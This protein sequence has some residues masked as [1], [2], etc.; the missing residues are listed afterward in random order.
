VPTQP[1]T[2]SGLRALEEENRRLRRAVRELSVLNDLAREIGASL[3]SQHIMSTIIT[4][5]LRAVRAEQGVIT[6]IDRHADDGMRTL[7][8]TEAGPHGGQALH[9]EESLLGWMQLNKRP[10]LIGDPPADDR[11]PGVRWDETVRSILCVP[12]LMKSELTGA[13]T[14]FN[15][16]GTDGFNEDDQRILSI[17]ASQSAQVVE[18]ARLHEEEESLRRMEEE[19]RLAS[20]IQ[21]G[22]LPDTAPRVPG[23]DIAGASVPAE[24]VGGDYFDFIR[25]D[26]SR[27]AICVG[28]V[29]GKGLSASLLMAN[30]QAT[31]RAQALVQLHPQA[32]LENANVLLSR[33]TDPHK[34]ATCFYAV[35]DADAHRLLHSNAGHEPPLLVSADGETDTLSAGGLVLGFV[36][37]LEY[38]EASVDMNPGDVLVVY[39]DGITDA[40]DADDVPFGERRLR[41][42]VTG[43]RSDSAAGLIESIF[44]AVRQHEGEPG[45]FDDMTLVVVK[46]EGT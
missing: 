32:C 20:E 45:Q 3:D 39:S 19:L 16:K 25:I 42:L 14:V 46:R 34:F 26:E 22:L 18:N 43:G 10:L 1:A 6:L 13:L 9:V 21:L 24:M 12:L 36:E 31:I 30:L 8:R 29:S 38:E 40:T 2:D 7:V 44:E 27:V 11:F 35:L 33:S 5:S 23:Y 17:V 37:P 41:E 15:K 4:R 28:D